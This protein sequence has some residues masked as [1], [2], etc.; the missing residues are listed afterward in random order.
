MSHNIPRKCV[1]IVVSIIGGFYMSENND[2]SKESKVEERFNNAK[3][4]GEIELIP[5]PFKVGD[6]V[7]NYGEMCKALGEKKTSGNSKV[8]QLESWGLFFEWEKEGFAFRITKLITPHFVRSQDLKKM[9]KK[10][11]EDMRRILLS[12]LR[13]ETF[14]NNGNAHFVSKTGLIKA[15]GLCNDNYFEYFGDRNYLAKGRGLKEEN[16]EDFYTRSYR[17]FKRDVEVIL[18]TLRNRA[19]LDYTETYVIT[20]VVEVECQKFTDAVE[21]EKGEKVRFEKKHAREATDEEANIITEA[22]FAVLSTMGLK[23]VGHAIMFGREKEFQKKFK[24]VL[25]SEYQMTNVYRAYKIWFPMSIAL[26]IENHVDKDYFKI[27]RTELIKKKEN[28]SKFVRE[29][30]NE[31]TDKV[32]A[33]RKKTESERPHDT[34]FNKESRSLCFHLIGYRAQAITDKFNKEV[35]ENIEEHHRKLKEERSEGAGF[36]FD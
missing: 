30:F 6:I 10:Y 8:S 18:Q 26:Y 19:M 9:N 23:D 3:E 35:E 32:I 33:S 4:K 27:D 36:D 31:T 2:V 29:S 13:N 21:L 1:I 11:Y 24:E 34:T 7:K 15:V 28:L 17:M 12:M 5:F 16:V 25:F 22:K 20:P 14:L